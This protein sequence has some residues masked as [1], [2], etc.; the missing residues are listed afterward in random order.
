M[1]AEPEPQLPAS[2]DVA[3]ECEA[4]LSG[5]YVEYLERRGQRIPEW[6]WLNAVAHAGSKTLRALAALGPRRPRRRVPLTWRDAVSFLAREL[7]S[8][9]G[10]PSGD[11][12]RFQRALVPLELDL[13]GG[14]RHTR[15]SPELLVSQGLAALHDR[16]AR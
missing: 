7:L 12:A 5:S 15:L 4:F 11:V 16:A 10:G 14:R 2:D 6:A 1:A 13:A 8:L 3:A 9:A